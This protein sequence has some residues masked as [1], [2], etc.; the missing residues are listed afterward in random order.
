[1]RT[2]WSFRA[3]ARVPSSPG[4]SAGSPSARYTRTR[5]RA[6][7]LMAGTPRGRSRF[8]GERGAEASGRRDVRPQPSRRPGG[9]VR[10]SSYPHPRPSSLFNVRTMSRARGW[11]R[12]GQVPARPHGQ[13]DFDEA[14]GPGAG[15]PRVV[16]GSPFLVEVT[17]WGRRG[18]PRVSGDRRAAATRVRVG[19]GREEWRYMEVSLPKRLLSPKLVSRNQCPEGQFPLVQMSL[20]QERVRYLAGR[21]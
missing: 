14:F 12:R 11:Q 1:M 18:G 16:Q 9:H 2:R 19:L 17:I 10:S 21:K 5:S 3:R 13:S 15:V 4:R 6:H 8:L 20:K 7:G